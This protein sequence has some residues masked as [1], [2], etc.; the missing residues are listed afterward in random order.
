MQRRPRRGSTRCEG[1]TI[2][3]LDISKPGG[4]IF[5]DRIETC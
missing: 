1:K 4:S 2:A 5:L 3:L